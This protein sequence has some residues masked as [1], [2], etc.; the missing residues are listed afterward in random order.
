MM[1]FHTDFL[2]QFTVERSSLV[3]VQPSKEKVL[4]PPHSII[5]VAV[6]NIHF[7]GDKDWTPSLKVGWFLR[8]PNDVY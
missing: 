2:F 5:A 8:I 7:M 6:T 4:K 1:K 3:L